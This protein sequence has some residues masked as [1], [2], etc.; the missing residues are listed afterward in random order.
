MSAK[1]SIFF[2]ILFSALQV[3]VV[4]KIFSMYSLYLSGLF[5][6][7]NLIFFWIPYNIM[8][9]K[10]SHE[11]SRGFHS[12]MYYLITPIIGITLQPLAG[13]IAEKFGFETVFIIGVCSYIIPI[14][15]I[16]FLPSFE[17]EINVKKYFYE[18]KF[19]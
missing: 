12:G 14:I 11:E 1:V 3:F 18:N 9:F 6:G 13:I 15:L 16:K 4:I 19:N 17:Y 2:G 10:F 5:S 8:H 7:L